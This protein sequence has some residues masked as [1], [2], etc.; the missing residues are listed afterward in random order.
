[1]FRRFSVNFAVLSIFLD[2]GLS[3][4]A[5]YLAAVL[6]APLNVLPFVRELPPVRLP[7]ML[8]AA[9]PLIWVG[10]FLLLDVYDGR[11][12]LRIVDELSSLTL[13]SLLAVVSSAGLLYLSYRDVS[14]FLFL[15]AAALSFGLLLAWRLA[16]RA[17]FRRH[18]LHS[19]PRR[20]LI[21]GAG[22][23]ARRVAEQI[24]AEPAAG[25]VLAGFLNG[26]GPH[27]DLPGEHLGTL[28]EVRQVVCERE[29]DDVVLALPAGE[30]EQVRRLVDRLQDLPVHIWVIPDQISLAL[31]TARVEE[32]GGT[33]MFDLR[34][35]A[36]DDYQRLTKRMFDIV[37]TLLVMPLAL[38][39]M[40]IAALL[41]RLD[42]P[43][44][45]LYR[46]KRVGENGRIFTMYKFRTMVTGADRMLD[47]SPDENGQANHKRPDDPRVTR[48]GRF[49]RKTS[50]DELPQLFN[51]L[52]GDMSLVGPR[53]ELP[54][55]VERY[56]AWQRE[57][58]AVP[59][60]LTGWWQVN[61]RSDKPMHLH[62]EE[63]LFYVRNYSIWLDLKILIK[64][65][66]VVLKG[67]G[68]F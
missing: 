17:V 48:V 46:A 53:P 31:H 5:L 16:A 47:L 12:N 3:S 9:F 35:P 67:K 27:P 1:M 14:R 39:A 34:A 49:L 21:L 60:G 38:P 51:V 36:L 26:P 44:P 23:A 19:S 18:G 62:T 32:F 11:K 45:V 68:A 4:L 65:A 56:L 59:Q 58:F 42:S 30:H 66:W 6:R 29:I 61:G 28:A 2:A 37:M 20:V 15:L 13:G 57:R 10:C 52:R 40:G 55:L 64:T 43:G 8:F 22:E 7:G 25:L 33:L 63:D 24:R 50:L 54:E 41:V